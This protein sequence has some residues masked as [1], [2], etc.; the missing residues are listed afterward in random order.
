MRRSVIPA[1]IA[2]ACVSCGS[3]THSGSPDAGAHAGGAS[4]SSAGGAGTSSGG[5]AS[6][7]GKASSGGT[8]GATSSGGA[9]GRGASGGASGSTNGDAGGAS[10]S[11]GTSDSG[12]AADAGT[13]VYGPWAGGAAYYRKFSRG[14]SSSSS[15]F[16]ISVWLQSP[17][18]AKDYAAIGIN[19]YVGLYQGPTDA[20]LT[21]LAAAPMPVA[22]DQNSVG[23]AHLT[24]KTIVAWTQQDEPDNAQ[25]ATGGGYGPCIS[26]TTIQGLYTQ[27]RGKDSTRPVYLNLGQG[28]AHDYIG[29]G[30]ECAATHPKDYPDYVK[31]ADIVSFDIYPSNDTDTSVHGKLWLVADGVKNLVGWAG[32]SKP[33][34]N[35]IECTGMNDPSGKPTPA[36]VKAEVWMSIVS[37][38][39]GIGYFVHQFMPTFDEHALLDD[40]TMKAAVAAINQQITTLAPVLNTPPIVGAGTVASS[41]A[42]VPVEM[43]MKRQGGATYVFAVAMRGTAVHAKFSALTGVGAASTA[44]VLGENRTVPVAGGAFEDDFPAWGVHLYEL[45]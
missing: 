42:S 25:A 14:P 24:D 32:S 34:W 12:T 38:S 1:F 43:L 45:K 6:G 33:V 15:F 8:S 3:D 18:R 28:V 19:T 36:Q 35:W 23:L 27:M 39:M 20:M 22:C 16:P 5:T 10:G 31:A 4:A 40:S 29:W 30:S 9:S 44:T 7:G 37:G 21:T 11:T 41:D 2:A 13:D 17:D 26:A